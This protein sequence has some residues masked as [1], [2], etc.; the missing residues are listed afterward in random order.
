MPCA[1]LRGAVAVANT[2]IIYTNKLTDTHTNTHTQGDTFAENSFY[3]LLRQLWCYSSMQ[4]LALNV[5]RRENVAWCPQSGMCV[6]VGGSGR[7]EVG[8]GACVCSERTF[9]PLDF[10]FPCQAMFSAFSIFASTF[11]WREHINEKQIQIFAFYLLFS[12]YFGF[13]SAF[14][15]IA[16][17]RWVICRIESEKKTNK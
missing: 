12:L 2:Y 5:R 11:A 10:D 15:S 8:S 4:S 17:R 7:W 6:Y 16:E 3:P 14:V 1:A 13:R 9:G